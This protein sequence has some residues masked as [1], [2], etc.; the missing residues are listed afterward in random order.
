MPIVEQ[1]MTALYMRKKGPTFMATYGL[2]CCI[3]KENLK[4]NISG[5]SPR[6]KKPHSSTIKKW[7]S[8]SPY[9]TFPPGKGLESEFLGG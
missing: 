2:K 8:K 5:R 3:P 7:G 6:N 9:H 4:N 1:A